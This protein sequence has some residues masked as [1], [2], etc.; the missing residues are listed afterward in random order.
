MIISLI[1]AVGLFISPF[2]YWPW[3]IVPYEIPRVLFI[4]Y[5]IDILSLIGFIFFFRRFKK[6]SFNGLLY[7]SVAC[8]FIVMVIASILGRDI[9]KSFWGN[10]Y[11]G[12]GLLT[13]FHLLSLFSFMMIYWQNKWQKLTAYAI[14]GGAAIIGLWSLIDNY[15]LYVLNDFSISH[16]SGAVGMTFGHSRFLA[17][18][19]L[20]TLPFVYYLIRISNRRQRWLMAAG[21][22]FQIAAIL[23]TKAWA[24]YLGIAVFA[25]LVMVLFCRNK[26]IKTLTVTVSLVIILCLLL[27]FFQK[28]NRH[29]FVAE[30]RQRIIVK[31]I[32]GTLKRPIFGWGWANADYAFEA[33]PWPMPISHDI[34]VDKAHSVFLEIFATTGIVGFAAY[35]SLLGYA[36]FSLLKK[37]R[38]SAGREK[39]WQKTLLTVFILYVFHSQ[40]NIISIAEEVIFWFVLGVAANEE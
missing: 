22:G 15:R 31:T 34:Y 5:W 12:D 24:G 16:W 38:G 6:R 21:L 7:L 14:G 36:G 10:Y 33:A 35:I 27:I 28:Q 18:Y 4:R 32:L 39:V 23:L 13:Y 9:N 26:P 37:A 8:F 20:V 3:A 17:G 25:L 40:T 29:D 1:I 11:R 30:S 2:V 19:L